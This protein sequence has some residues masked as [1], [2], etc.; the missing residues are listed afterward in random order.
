MLQGI[1]CFRSKMLG[2][3][4]KL[5]LNT[6]VESIKSHTNVSEGLSHL[7]RPIAV[8]NQVVV[9]VPEE[10]R[11]R[12]VHEVPSIYNQACN[13]KQ[14][15]ENLINNRIN[16][17]LNEPPFLIKPVLRTG[18]GRC[19]IYDQG[20]IHIQN[21]NVIAHRRN[22]PNAVIETYVRFPVRDRKHTIQVLPSGDTI[23]LHINDDIDPF[24]LILRI[25]ASFMERYKEVTY[26]VKEKLADDLLNK[27]IQPCNIIKQEFPRLQMVNYSE[28]VKEP[29]E[30]GIKACNYTTWYPIEWISTS[31]IQILIPG[32]NIVPFVPVSAT[33]DRLY[34]HRTFSDNYG[35]EAKAKWIVLDLVVGEKLERPRPTAFLLKQETSYLTDHKFLFLPPSLRTVHSI[36]L[37]Y[38]SGLCYYNSTFTASPISPRYPV[39][40]TMNPVSLVSWRCSQASECTIEHLSS[41][42]FPYGKLELALLQF[43]RPQSSLELCNSLP[44]PDNAVSSYKKLDRAIRNKIGRHWRWYSWPEKATVNII[45]VEA[46]AY[47]NTILSREDFIRYYENTNQAY[48]LYYDKLMK[49]QLK[50]RNYQFDYNRLKEE[51]DRDMTKQLRQPIRLIRNELF[52][53]GQYLSL[54]AKKLWK[55]HLIRQDL[56]QHYYAIIRAKQVLEIVKTSTKFN[57][58]E[59]Y[60][61][62][63]NGDYLYS[64]NRFRILGQVDQEQRYTMPGIEDSSR[65]HWEPGKLV[66]LITGTLAAGTALVYGAY[67]F[68]ISN[69]STSDE[70]SINAEISLEAINDYHLN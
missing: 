16:V 52:S 24:I 19:T 56:L 32:G 10:E 35:T 54:Y 46:N 30:T 4:L 23:G 14:F 3:L 7:L 2:Y 58:D 51:R 36:F 31:Q 70:V 12:I 39:G 22:V 63:L 62:R 27:I 45:N 57:K 5:L 53:K 18:Y 41:R 65:G 38:E 69:F 37:Y 59:I 17:P 1:R 20:W 6:E 43:E 66:A 9:M 48:N 26:Q 8:N 49:T 67:N 44:K 40:I 68:F 15:Y 50:I 29:V 60:E 21:P 34:Y 33:N 13:Q 55:I 64:W 28:V 42:I 11:T 47:L 61:H 25:V